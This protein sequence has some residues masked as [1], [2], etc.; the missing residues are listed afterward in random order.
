MEESTKIIQ[1][2]PWKTSFGCQRRPYTPPYAAT[3]LTCT[4]LNGRI[5]QDYSR[6]TMED[7][8]RMSKEAIHASI[9]GDTPHM[10]A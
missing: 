6:K 8:L 5:H 10:M 3:L 9:C 4:A 1:E 7:L 2:R